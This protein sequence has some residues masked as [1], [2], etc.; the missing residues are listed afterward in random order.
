MIRLYGSSII[1]FHYLVPP[2]S[3]SQIFYSFSEQPK[4]E[5]YS[6]SSLSSAHPISSATTQSPLVAAHASSGPVESLHAVIVSCHRQK[7]PLLWIRNR[8]PRMDG[9]DS[10][11]VSFSDD[12]AEG[13]YDD[14]E[15]PPSSYSENQS[16]TNN[17]G[18]DEDV[19]EDDTQVASVDQ[20]QRDVDV[21]RELTELLSVPGGSN[22]NPPEGKKPL[23]PPK[24]R[25]SKVVPPTTIPEHE[26]TTTETEA[27]T[28]QLSS[29]AVAKVP[30]S[31]ATAGTTA[32]SVDDESGADVE[33]KSYHFSGSSHSPV[34]LQLMPPQPARPDDDLDVSPRSGKKR[35][36]GHGSRGTK[37]RSHDGSQ[38]RSGHGRTTEA[39]NGR[40]SAAGG[41]RIRWTADPDESFSDWRIDVVHDSAGGGRDVYH[42]HRNV[43]GFGPRKSDYLLKDFRKAARDDV[44]FDRGVCVTR[45][46]LPAA[47]ARVFPMV[48]DFMY[49][50]K[51][52]RQTLTAERACHVFKLAELLSIPALQNAIAEFYMKN[53]SLKNLGEFLT[54]ANRNKADALLVVSKAKIGQMIT[55]KPELSGLVPPKF[56][57]DIVLISR[58]QLDDAREKEPDKYSE[59]LVKS[60]SR[61]WSKA[62]CICASHNESVMTRKL[63]E[64]LTSKESLPHIDASVAP[65]FLSL[66]AKLNP[67]GGNGKASGQL[68]SLQRRCV[69]SISDDFDAFQRGFSSPEAVSET[70][71][72]VPSYVLAEILVKSMNRS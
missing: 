48:L 63:F 67:Q 26:A 65:Q 71:Q 5:R 18:E 25:K 38:R 39:G 21:R 47:R 35:H 56:L 61:Y 34:N 9:H 2:R 66:D 15:P 59:E 58:R 43:C 41:P 3:Y 8:N 19:D 69:D 44:P 45:L 20:L 28:G 62:A 22:K 54:A 52:A 13:Y 49:Y 55:E 29:T 40:P 32:P 64:T 4:R 27:G 46:D 12:A 70:L 50:C 60:Q 57:A 37:S 14:E 7:R 23:S 1:L 30:S 11:I 42:V 6:T 17:D 16:Y 68:N 24:S 33:D 10:D 36:S 72:Q 31:G 51:E 53:L